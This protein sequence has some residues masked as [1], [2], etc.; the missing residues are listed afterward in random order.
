MHPVNRKGRPPPLNQP[1]FPSAGVIRCAMQFPVQEVKGQRTS[2]IPRKWPIY[3][4]GI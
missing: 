1:L 3:R 4:S 2:K